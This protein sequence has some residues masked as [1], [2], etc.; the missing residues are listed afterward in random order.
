MSYKLWRPM[1]M[2]NRQAVCTAISFSGASATLGD[3]VVAGCIVIC[4]AWFIVWVL[5]W[6]MLDVGMNGYVHDWW[7]TRDD[8]SGEVHILL[9]SCGDTSEVGLYVLCSHLRDATCGEV[10]SWWITWVRL[11]AGRFVELDHERT[12]SWKHWNP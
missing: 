1:V 3:G 5:V 2:W 4:F 8:M 12:G 9:L 6:D 11:W 7:W 10:C